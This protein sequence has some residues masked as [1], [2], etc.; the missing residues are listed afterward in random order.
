MAL[1]VLLLIVDLPCHAQLEESDTARWQFNGGLSLKLNTGNV[2]RMIITPEANVA[3]V[4]KSKLWGFSARERYTFGTFGKYHTE[5]DLLLRNFIY[6][7]PEKRVYPYVMAWFQ[8][9]ERQRL[10]FRYQIGPGVT[11]VPLRRS[12][13]IIKL[14]A[15]ATYEQNWY[16]E[17]SLVFLGDYT[18][19]QYGTFRATVRLFGSHW[20]VKKVLWLYYEVLFQQS[21]TNINNWRIFAEGGVNAQLPKGFSMRTYVSYEYQQVHVK[22]EKPNDLILNVGVNYRISSRR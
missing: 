7:I 2:D 10:L 13:Q 21:L 4:S 5:N 17:D 20:A 12:G 8:T 9:H 18:R 14:S 16:K 22:S 6:F 11:V 15:T 1:S 3:H 19:K